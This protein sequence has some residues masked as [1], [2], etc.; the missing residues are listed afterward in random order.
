M[1]HNRLSQNVTLAE[2]GSLD[3]RA[4]ATWRKLYRTAAPFRIGRAL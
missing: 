4:Q 3:L 2:L 1:K